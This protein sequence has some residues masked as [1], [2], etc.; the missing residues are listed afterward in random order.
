MK[1]SLKV[2]P[3]FFWEWVGGL[4]LIQG[5]HIPRCYVNSEWQKLRNVEVC[6]FGDASERGYGA[7]VYLRVP[8]VSGTYDTSLVISRARVAPLKKQ[9]L[10]RLE[11]LGALLCAKLVVFVIKSLRLP[12]DTN[13]K[14]WTDSTVVLSWIYTEPYQLKTFVANRI[15]QI[16]E[17]TSSSS[18]FHCSGVENPADLVTRGVFANKLISSKLWLQGPK[19]LAENISVSGVS[20]FWLPE[21]GDVERKVVSLSVQ[22]EAPKIFDFERWSSFTKALN[23]V[24]Y[25]CRFCQN[26]R[27][28]VSDRVVGSDLTHE[29]LMNA[30]V[31]MFRCIQKQ[32][33]FAEI[34]ALRENGSVA[35]TSSIASLDPYLS[36]DEILRTKGRLQL[37]EL[38][39]EEKHP[40][41]L[42][43]CH[44][45]LLL[46]RHQHKLLNHAGVD[47]LV[48]TLRSG[49]WI[50]GLRRQAKR[51]KRECVA[52]KRLD[53]KHCSQ[54][55]APLPEMRVTKA[56]AFSVTG[57]DYCGP[58]YCVDMPAKKHYILLFTCA[59]VRAI[60]LE[61]TDSLALSDCI[62]AIRRFASRRGLPKVFHS[63]NA[64]TFVGADVQ[65][66]KYFGHCSPHWRYLVPRAPWWGGYYERLVGSVK[67][68]LKRSL[69]SKC[70]TRIELET[71]LCEVECCINSRPL[72]FV[73]DSIDSKTPLSPNHFLT[74]RVAG[75][76]PSDIDVEVMEVSKQDL[77][78]R[79]IVRQ[80]RLDEF[81]AL[82]SKD[83]L[84]NLPPA[85]KEFVPR[86]NLKEGSVVLIRENNLTRMKWPMGVVVEAFSGNDGVVR[87]VKLKTSRGM[88]VRAVQKL[89]DL[90]ISDAEGSHED[91]V[92]QNVDGKMSGDKSKEVITRSGR[93]V[94]PVVRMDL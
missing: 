80:A 73:G 68:A 7:C 24:G 4:K 11:L 57:L 33:Y 50:V 45:S 37:S 61:L 87:S 9:T 49:Y 43:K 27:R 78:E 17:L 90:E 83:Y 64:K 59:V 31:V 93:V 70:L 30:K 55:V 88:V 21:E 67:S 42:P 48:S 81:W 63:D 26:L 52:C 76:V 89:H 13:Y 34:Q 54:P 51:V 62:L 8:R 16:Q 20:S 36:K 19:W 15:S 40:V 75:F 1:K 12:L 74:G 85:L 41:I 71:T 86:C 39:F 65:L 25:V 18:W 3:K 84:R 28:Q 94:K 2:T 47:T 56:P 69:G 72:T 66:R 92:L 53:S 29:E 38:S 46:V 77:T 82:W 32:H 23:I 6:G 91:D 5:W 22:S 10:P 60:H 44:L 79:E 58:L 35:K 14:C